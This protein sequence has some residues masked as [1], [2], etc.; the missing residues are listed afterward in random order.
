MS[1][2]DTLASSLGDDSGRVEFLA[3]V[4]SL[5][6]SAGFLSH[7]ASGDNRSAHEVS[8]WL[9]AL[10]IGHRE[11]IFLLLEPSQRQVVSFEANC[12]AAMVA[13]GNYRRANASLRTAE[14]M[15]RSVGT[16]EGLI[17]RFHEPHN[18]FSGLV[19]SSRGIASSLAGESGT[20]PHRDPTPPDD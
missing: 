12:A 16:V 13:E 3:S 1:L 11:A 2:L 9:K 17:Q 7:L 4:K 14:T 19:G 8:D 20:L 15:L 5:E 18:S 10:Q 6:E